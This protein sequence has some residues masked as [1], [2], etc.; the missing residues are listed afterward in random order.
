MMH[1]I[2]MRCLGL[3]FLSCLCLLLRAQEAPADY[4][5]ARWEAY[6]I[7]HPDIQGQEFAVLNFRKMLELPEVPE[8][9]LVHVSAD[10]RYKFYV[11]GELLCHGPASG[12]QRNWQYETV[13]IAASLRKGK[14][15]LKA[16]VWNFGEERPM[17]H[18]SI[19]TAF[20]LQAADVERNPGISSD[21]SWQVFWNRAYQTKPEWSLNTDIG[22]AEVL[23]FRLADTAWVTALK[24]DHGQTKWSIQNN[25]GRFLKPREIPLMRMETT[26]LGL[27]RRQ[28]GMDRLDTAVF[29][30]KE[31][32]TVPS[33]RKVVLLI[34]QEELINAYPVLRFS[35]GKGARVQIAYAESL[36]HPD[37]RKGNRN[38]IE[39]KVFSGFQD[40]FIASGNDG[41][42]SP[43]WYRTFRYL[44]LSIETGADP[45]QID[46]LYALKEEYPFDFNARFTSKEPFIDSLLEV[47]WR[48][49]KLCA[50]E[51]YMDCP[52]YERLQY[53][54]DT[55]IQGLVSLY[56]SGDDRLLRQ[57]LQQ[58]DNSRMSEGITLSRYPTNHDQQIPPFSLWWVGMVH[59][60]WMY[61]GDESFV[62]SFL[63]GI[64]QVLSFFESRSLPDGSIGPIPYWNFTDWVDRDG[65]IFGIGPNGD[66]GSALIDL[67]F[68][69]AC[70]K[71][72]DLE[73]NLGSDAL[74][75]EYEQKMA[76]LKEAI[77]GKYW[78]E[79]RGLFAD[80]V[81]KNYFSQ[82][83]N[84]LAILTRL[85]EGAEAESVMLKVIDDE[86]LAQATIYFKFY[87]FMAL[88]KVGMADRYLEELG[89]WKDHLA[90]GLSTWAEISDVNTTRSDCHAWG[91]SP[92]IELFR[93]VLGIDSDAAGFSKVRISPALGKLEEASGSIPH[94]KGQLEVDYKKSGKRWQI[95]VILPRE[96]P[97]ELIWEGKS[98]P[99][100][101]GKETKL[102]I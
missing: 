76:Q 90:T 97:G 96:T 16:E 93:M 10:S 62:R 75:K 39:G 54:G 38:E 101:A 73:R 41:Q 24:Q 2:R 12:D 102:T 7:T 14:N 15:I 21:D 87:E 49:A 11:N 60:Y 13:D 47:G 98:Y 32:F 56:N 99:L 77:R 23:D 100:A 42:Y 44:Q 82:H 63:P 34:D 81:Q 79:E 45:L 83:S 26:R 55:R 50:V 19:E 29:Q 64:R 33:N 61:R 91:A 31:A 1:K 36:H 18:P 25:A 67:Q 57:A 5:K 86:E 94:P 71:A 85:V 9:L 69:Y 20:I 8:T 68:L 48:T 35:K 22:G 84:V 30:K 3:A 43:L 65:W 74:A 89:V 80:D 95:R 51:T 40:M 17:A 70:Q 58:F 4:S 53:I 6:W 28:E 66:Q 37:G 59:D 72:I 27:L 46:D 88:K 52:Y 78:S 92:N